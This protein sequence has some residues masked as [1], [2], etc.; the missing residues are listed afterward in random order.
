MRAM[1]T[2]CLGK[3]ASGQQV[4]PFTK[5]RKLNVASAAILAFACL[6]MTDGRAR[7]SC[8][9]GSPLDSGMQSSPNSTYVDCDCASCV[10]QCPGCSPVMVCVVFHCTAA[11]CGHPGVSFSQCYNSS[12]IPRNNCDCK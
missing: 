3:P 5:R 1:M 10:C 8:N 11:G 6:V 2:A 12:Q 9:I 4:E 7:A